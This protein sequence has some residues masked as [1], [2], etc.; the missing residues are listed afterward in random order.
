MTVV[1][2]KHG[3]GWRVRLKQKVN[4]EWRVTDE[5]SGFESER[6][7][8]AEAKKLKALV[9]QGKIHTRTDT[10]TV[11]ACM[12]KYEKACAHKPSVKPRSAN[13]PA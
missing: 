9:R 6:E 1:V 3:G 12:T 8:R 11:D 13:L 2:E 7:A 10:P 5:A 4:G